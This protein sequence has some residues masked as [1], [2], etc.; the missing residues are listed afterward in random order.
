MIPRIKKA[1]LFTGEHFALYGL[2]YL[3]FNI[4]RGVC[5]AGV[6]ITELRVCHAA[7]VDAV[8]EGLVHGLALAVHGPA[9]GQAL[10]I[11][12]ALAQRA[13]SHQQTGLEPAAVL[14]K[15]LDIHVGGPEALIALHGGEVGG[16]G[17]EPA[18]QGVGFF[19]KALAAAM[20]TGKVFRQ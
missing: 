6:D 15:A 12:C 2:V 4:A 14:V 13:D 5:A 7:A 16:A 10:L 8:A 11:G 9:V 3:N 17:I 20:R 18:V 1:L 19:I